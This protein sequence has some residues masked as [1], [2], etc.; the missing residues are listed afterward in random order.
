MERFHFHRRSQATSESLCEYVAELWKLSTHCE[1]GECLYE[2]LRDRLVSG[3]RSEAIQRHL[4]SEADL[5]FS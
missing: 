5:T 4:L 3:L 1:F 2:A